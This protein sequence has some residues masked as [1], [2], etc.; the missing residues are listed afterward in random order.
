MWVGLL[1]AGCALSAARPEHA[2]EQQVAVDAASCSP[3]KGYF[4]MRNLSSAVP[5]SPV[6]GRRRL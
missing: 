2:A 6:S 4:A 1:L 5:D 3:V